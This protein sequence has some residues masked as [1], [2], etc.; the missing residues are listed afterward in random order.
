VRSLYLEES[1]EGFA[2]HKRVESAVI[3]TECAEYI[4]QRSEDFSGS[5]N[6][7]DKK[8]MKDNISEAVILEK[9][10]KARRYIKVLFIVCFALQNREKGK[11]LF[12]YNFLSN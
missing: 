4:G 9:K 7:F 6:I 1:F 5:R 3:E 12:V 10:R 8:C 2:S 11:K